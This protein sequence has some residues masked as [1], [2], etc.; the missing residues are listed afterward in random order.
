VTEYIRV[1]VEGCVQ[2]CCN[3]P[4]YGRLDNPPYTEDQLLEIG[5][6][7]VNEQHSWGYHV[8]NEEDVPEDER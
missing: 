7:M 3:D 5:Q 6:D 2:G 4:L 1:D 8:V